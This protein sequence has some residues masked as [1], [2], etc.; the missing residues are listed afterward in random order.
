MRRIK[1][2]GPEAPERAVTVP[3]TAFDVAFTIMPGRL[4]LDALAEEIY[5]HGFDGAALRLTGDLGPF[6]Y[7]M[8]ALATD[9]KTAAWYSESYRP[10]GITRLDAASLT[11]G[12][13]DGRPF[14]HCHGLWTEADG[15]VNAGHLLPE[16]V[17]AA[18]PVSVTGVGIHGARFDAR[19]DPETGFTLLG[20]VA[21][22]TAQAEGGRPALA[23]RL[24]PNQDIT[25]ALAD[26]AR[27]QGWAA[28]Q[29][30]GGVGSIIGARYVGG[31][32]D[33]DDFATEMLVRG[34]TGTPDD[35]SLDVALV[36][37]KGKVGGGRLVP[38]DNPVLMTL[39]AVM[40]GA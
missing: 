19:P 10:E 7:V 39:E 6:A 17:A 1:Q 14:Y 32:G 25:E 29:L 37:Y 34:V 20:P 36:D 35:L 28:P 33:T 12:W 2:P 21:T 24:R 27:S 40:T 11:L 8:P 22:E 9:G 13:R 26:L 16:A 15:T 38:G 5:T 23:L 18:G 4:L 31:A 30:E 3:V